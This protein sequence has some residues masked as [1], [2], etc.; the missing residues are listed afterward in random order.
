MT[1]LDEPVTFDVTFGYLDTAYK[2]RKNVE[3]P[4]DMPDEQF[5]P[6]FHMSN[7]TVGMSA[8]LSRRWTRRLRSWCSGRGVRPAY[9]RHRT[10][11][12]VGGRRGDHSGDAAHGQHLCATCGKS[13]RQCGY[14]QQGGSLPEKG[15]GE[16]SREGGIALVRTS[17]RHDRMR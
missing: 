8:R 4:F 2:C 11:Q 17:T 12:V 16:D 10:L 7:S 1:V 5:G 3:A 13:D 15:G 14:P 9:L 6:H